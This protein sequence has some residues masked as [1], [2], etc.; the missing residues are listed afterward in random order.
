[1]IF[2]SP[3]KKFNVFVFSKVIFESISDMKYFLNDDDE[4]IIIIIIIDKF[5]DA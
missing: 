4:V 1:M 2:R 5:M 3:L